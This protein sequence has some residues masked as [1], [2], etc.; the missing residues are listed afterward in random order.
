MGI[1]FS[2]ETV[3]CLLL[4]LVSAILLFYEHTFTCRSAV[5]PGKWNPSSGKHYPHSQ[6]T[7]WMLN[8]RCVHVLHMFR[9]W[10]FFSHSDVRYGDTFTTL[11]YFNTYSKQKTSAFDS[12]LFFRIMLSIFR[13]LFFSCCRN[14]GESVNSGEFSNAFS[15]NDASSIVI[16]TLVS[17]R[18]AN[19]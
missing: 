19:K 7:R 13:C 3:T 9:V 12:G 4:S 15:C 11:C 10:R 6:P 14:F 16:N 17:M 1:G 2:F 18:L 5:I 8:A